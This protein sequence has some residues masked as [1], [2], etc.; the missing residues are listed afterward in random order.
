MSDPGA[1][2]DVRPRRARTR[3]R[4]RKR[5]R[6]F[7]RIIREGLSHPEAGDAVL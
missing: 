6:F 2:S 4:L 1:L 3:I 7:G 5:R